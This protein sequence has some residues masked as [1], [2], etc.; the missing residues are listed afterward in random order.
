MD[1]LKFCLMHKDTPVCALT[2]DADSGAILRVSKP[3]NPEIL[4]LGGNID[5]AQLRK[6]WQNRAVPMGQGRIKRILENAGIPS[7]QAYLVKNWG[8]SLTDHYWIKPFDFAFGWNEINLFSN[9]FIDPVGDMQFSEAIET[10]IN[11]PANAFSPSSSLQGDLR[12][13]WIIREG[14]RYLVKGNHGNNSQE[15]LNEVVATLL[16]SKQ[17]KQPYVSYAPMRTEKDGQIYCICES[18]T[19]NSLELI[20]AYEVIESQ[21]KA[22]FSSIYEHFI[23]VC[24][25][26][27][28]SESVIRPFLEYQILTD[29]ILSN[30]D[31]HLRNVGILRDSATLQFV[32]MAPIFD[33]GNSMFYQN[34]HL[35]LNDDLRSLEVNSFRSKEMELLRYVQGN[36]LVDMTRLPTTDELEDVYA[37]DSLINYTDAILLGYRKKIDIIQ[38]SGLL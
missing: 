37:R 36:H 22:N 10:A 14:K 6:W 23:R 17:G 1:E 16:H 30:T 25:E 11:L 2:I 33:T 12:K 18:F 29:F 35:P 26:H 15:S 31:R 24:T 28:L 27:G 13:K 19:T 34:P 38:E 5:A 4:P 7:T 8:L 9:N 3:V 21:K 20:T 32:G